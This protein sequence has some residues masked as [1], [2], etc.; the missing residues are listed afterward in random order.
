MKLSSEAFVANGAIPSKF[1]CDGD[2]CNPP[3]SIDMV[4]AEAQALALIMDDPDAPGGNWVH[5]LLWDLNPNTGHIAENSLPR[6]AIKGKNSWG[7]NAY[8]GPCPPS[9]IHRYVF[10]LF[11]L[12][13]PLRLPEGADRNELDRALKGKVLSQC[14]LVGTYRRGGR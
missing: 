13:E 7:R 6:E 3:L 12:A 11:A 8:G 4:P 9:G 14:E 1:T 2:D 10:R 5:W